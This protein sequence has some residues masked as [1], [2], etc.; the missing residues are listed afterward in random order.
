[1][2]FRLSHSTVAFWSIICDALLYALIGSLGAHHFANNSAPLT[3]FGLAVIVAACLPD[4]ALDLP[5]TALQDF[6]AHL[7]ALTLFGSSIIL[8]ALATDLAL[9]L[10]IALAASGAPSHHANSSHHNM[11]LVSL[12]ALLF[13]SHHT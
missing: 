8:N 13:G 6:I 1:M 11:L 3:S 5:A 4:Q 9:F 10:A 12:A 7:N 2:F